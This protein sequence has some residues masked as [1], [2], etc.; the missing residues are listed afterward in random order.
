MSSQDNRQIRVE[1]IVS[2]EELKKYPIEELYVESFPA[3]E[4]AP[5][6]LMLRTIKKGRAEML[7]A[8]ENEEMVGFS[9][10]VCNETLAYIFYLAVREDLRGKGFGSVLLTDMKERYKG[11]KLFLAREQLDESAD[12]Y[13]QRKKRVQFYQKNGFVDLPCKIKEASVIF[14][15]MGIGGNVSAKEYHDLIVKWGGWLKTRILDMHII[16]NE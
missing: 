8:I 7:V 16:E 13:E 11:K 10:M 14:A 5:Y 3:A 9:Y 15:V 12:N 6:R 2:V 4:R 1:R